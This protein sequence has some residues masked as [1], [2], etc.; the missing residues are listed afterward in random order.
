MRKFWRM[1]LEFELFKTNLQVAGWE[2][3][4]TCSEEKCGLSTSLIVIWKKLTLTSECLSHSNIDNNQIGLH[5]ITKERE[6]CLVI[7]QK[8]QNPTLNREYRENWIIYW[9][10]TWLKCPLWFISWKKTNSSFRNKLFNTTWL[11]PT[12]SAV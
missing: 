6:L 4:S 12:K 1:I 11:L 7:D 2:Q 10:E 5:H 8:R 3:R 9:G